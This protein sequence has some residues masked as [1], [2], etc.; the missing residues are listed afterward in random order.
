MKAFLNENDGSFYLSLT[1]ENIKE[2]ATIARCGMNST[3][4]M[5]VTASIFRDGEFYLELNIKKNK[6]SSSQIKNIGGR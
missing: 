6:N 1:P 2:A 4:E 5:R 3:K